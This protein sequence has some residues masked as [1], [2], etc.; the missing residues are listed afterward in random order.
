MSEYVTTEISTAENRG[1]K[2]MD[3]VEE[4][5]TRSTGTSLFLSGNFSPSFV[6]RLFGAGG[7]L[8]ERFSHECIKHQLSNRFP[9]VKQRLIKSWIKHAIKQTDNKGTAGWFDEIWFNIS[10][11]NSWHRPRVIFERHRSHCEFKRQATCWTCVH[12]TTRPCP[13]GIPIGRPQSS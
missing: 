5:A 2:T 11:R 13:V 3:P 1:T 6:T 10:F 4:D 8:L 7:I 12:F 9:R